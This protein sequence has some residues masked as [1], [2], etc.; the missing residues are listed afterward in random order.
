MLNVQL[1]GI[2]RLL[3]KE[4]VCENV[5]LMY[6]QNYFNCQDMYKKY[7][8]KRGPRFAITFEQQLNQIFFMNA[9][10]TFVSICSFKKHTT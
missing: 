7:F 5:V 9:K 10:N 4:L 3:F 2:F 6:N 8:K 1:C